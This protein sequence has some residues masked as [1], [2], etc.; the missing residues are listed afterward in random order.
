MRFYRDN[1][2]A[3][4]EGDAAEYIFFVVR[5][6]VRSCKIFHHGARNIVAF[7]LPGD[8]FGWTDLKH[9]LSIEA[10]T[11]TELPISQTECLAVHRITGK[12]SCKFFISRNNK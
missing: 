6:V 8:P 2:I 7:Y 12:S 11:D 4:C 5:G 10:A 1:L 3:D 9:S